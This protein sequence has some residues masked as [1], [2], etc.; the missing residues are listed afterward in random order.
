[1]QASKIGSILRGGIGF[2]IVSLAGFS[3]WA[4]GGKWL[5]RHF[6]EAGLYCGC[7]V[8]FLG[9][10]GL[11]LHPLLPG[12]RSLPR[13]YKVFLPAFFA[14]SILWCAAW[15]RLRFGPGEWM[16][17]L[18][19]TFAFATVTAWRL[20]NYR[21]LV[22]TG[23]VLFVLHSAGYFLGGYSM[24][25]IGGSAGSAL[26]TGLSKSQ[27]AATAKLSWGLLYGLGFGAGADS[28]ESG[29]LFQSVSDTIPGL[30]DSCRSEATL[31]VTHNGASDRSQVLARTFVFIRSPSEGRRFDR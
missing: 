1:M 16:G 21:G 19:G 17:S 2:G 14:Y 18:L 29:H 12:P 26:L 6:G 13:F 30:S 7:A 20:R 22:T 15:F 11:L 24:Q 5:T 3:V 25:W 4:F 31:W 9:S 8:V 28:N 10:S 27:I 23:L